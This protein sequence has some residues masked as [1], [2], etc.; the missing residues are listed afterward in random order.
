MD[1]K[2]QMGGPEGRKLTSKG[3]KRKI[4]ETAN[5]SITDQLHALESFNAEWSGDK[6]QVDDML[7][8]GFDF[9]PLTNKQVYYTYDG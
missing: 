4:I 9:N 8:I 5:L 2:D 3:F 1:L 6:A 7:I